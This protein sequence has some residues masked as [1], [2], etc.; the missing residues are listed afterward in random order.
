MWINLLWFWKILTAFVIKIAYIKDK[1]VVI[2]EKPYRLC[3]RDSL[4]YT[5]GGRSATGRGGARG[6]EERPH[7]WRHRHSGTHTVGT[8]IP[9]IT[10]NF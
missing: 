7:Q 5:P 3:N 1:L 9:G 4:Y 8:V 2:S 10:W 6:P